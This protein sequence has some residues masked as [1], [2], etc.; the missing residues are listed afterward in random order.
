MHGERLP[1]DDELDRLL[2]QAKWP[3]PEPG[4][5]QRLEAYWRQL[6]CRR[7][8]AV[9][10]LVALAASVL[11]A[12]GVG[13]WT[14]RGD[15]LTDSPLA[16]QGDTVC[17]V[18]TTE[19]VANPPSA[20]IVAREPTIYERVLLIDQART[21]R[22]MAPADSTRPSMAALEQTIA[23]AIASLAADADA[24]VSKELVVLWRKRSSS[25][26]MLWRIVR[27]PASEDRLGAVRLLARVASPRSLPVFLQLAADSHLHDSAVVGLARLVDDAQLRQL[28]M[29][30]SDRSLRQDLLAA[31]L[32]RNTPA[33]IGEYL[34]LVIDPERRVDALTALTDSETPPIELLAEYLNDSRSSVRL[35]TAQALGSLN[36]PRAADALRRSVAGI[37]RQEAFMALLVSPSPRASQIVYQARQDVYLMASVQAA[38]RQLHFLQS[39]ITVLQTQS[40]GN[41]P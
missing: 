14:L 17:R 20:A 40:G 2:S 21:R 27:R 1:S 28:A 9:G 15:P 35:A 5:L 8:S 12:A 30:E 18:A 36:D 32:A 6:Q 10:Y 34:G 19:S 25:E 33:A 16:T 23:A 13:Y 39:Q 22:R 41:L 4:Q 31:L 24:D 37:G 38:E 11:L 29:D 3:E 26:R 7:R